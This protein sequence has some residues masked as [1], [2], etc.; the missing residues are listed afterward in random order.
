VA[1]ANFG[2]LYAVMSREAGGLESARLLRLLAKLT[3]AG[4]VL[5]GVCVWGEAWL[6]AGWVDSSL[7]GKAVALS[8]VIGVGAL[9][10]FA[11]AYLL[12]VEELSELSES[13]RRRFRRRLEQASGSER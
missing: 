2:A 3:G 5:L 9:S 13:V 6:R 8:G 1:L 7:V 11:A 4:A 12:R 10:F